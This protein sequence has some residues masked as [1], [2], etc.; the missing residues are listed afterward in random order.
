MR[1]PSNLFIKVFVAF[2]LVMEGIPAAVVAAW[3]DP[4]LIPACIIASLFF[5]SFPYETAWAFL[6]SL[7]SGSGGQDYG[8]DNFRR[9]RPMSDPDAASYRAYRALLRNRRGRRR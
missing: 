2:W 9:G 3:H 4:L 6:T 7:F 5:W 1:L 8:P